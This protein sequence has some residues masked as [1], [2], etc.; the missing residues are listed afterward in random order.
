MSNVNEQH[1]RS[2]LRLAD[3]MLSL[4]EQADADRTDDS[5]GI[6]WGILRDMAYHLRRAALAE[7][8]KHGC[9]EDAQQGA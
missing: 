5:C 6:L 7:C 1:L 9:G 4:A 3:Q 2:C 8:A